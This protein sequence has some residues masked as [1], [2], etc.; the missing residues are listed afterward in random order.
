MVAFVTES[1]DI[2]VVSQPTATSAFISYFPDVIQQLEESPDGIVGQFVVE[3]DIAR[4]LDAGDVLVHF[5][6][7]YIFLQ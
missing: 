5:L 7:L 4:D 1:N 6:H 3:Y 2:A